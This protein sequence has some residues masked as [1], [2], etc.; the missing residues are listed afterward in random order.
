MKKG[1]LVNW[2]RIPP[3]PGLATEVTWRARSILCWAGSLPT[4]GAKD[5]ADGVD[6]TPGTPLSPGIPLEQLG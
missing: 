5:V 1:L 4:D 3:S 2:D 6:A